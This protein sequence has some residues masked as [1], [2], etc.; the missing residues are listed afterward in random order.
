M[1]LDVLAIAAHPDDIELSCASTVYKLTS[2]GKKVGILDLTQG[3]L[4]TR[5]SKEI[6]SKEAEVSS[7]ILGLSMRMNFKIPDG[8]I[9]VNKKNITR[10]IQIIRHYR[11]DILLFPHWL[12]RHPDHEHAHKVCREAWFYSGL[13]KIVTK[14]E[15][16]FQH[17]HRP[18][19][20]FH[21]MQ[22]Y[23]FQPSFI[24][25]VSK[26]YDKKKEVLAAFSSQFHNPKSTERETILSSKF[27]LES[28]YARDR[29]FGSLIN[30]EYGEPFYC[31]EPLGLDS[32][33]NL[34]IK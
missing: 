21:F 19:K 3:E 25:D 31:V 12:E 5:G 13:E 30:V 15:G 26:N 18:A 28:V 27:F 4:G 23:E 11:P 34:I 14:W 1:K 8:G 20:Y 24:V 9:E 17:P 10:V 16:K 29:H 2:E 22:K 7:K 33:F 32:F 6:R